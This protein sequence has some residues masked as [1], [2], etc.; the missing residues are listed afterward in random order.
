MQKTKWVHIILASLLFF[1]AVWF[2]QGRHWL[3]D[4]D[5]EKLY[6]LNVSVFGYN[7]AAAYSLIYILP[8][9][10]LLNLL[11]R[12][13]SAEITTRFDKR[14][15]L[16]HLFVYQ[17]I[18]LAVS[19]AVIQCCVNILWTT[20]FFDQSLLHQASFYQATLY[21]AIAFILF[22]LITAFCFKITE[23]ITKST[24]LSMGITVLL[25]ATSYFI[26]K[27]GISMTHWSL[28]RDVG[29]M[30]L[31]FNGGVVGINYLRLVV[32]AI[33]TSLLASMLFERKD[34]IT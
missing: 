25:F 34:F 26:E 8:F 5:Y 31:L 1:S 28:Y 30:E 9:L 33:I 15:S 32:I 10:L 17:S 20:L 27:I 24:A 3:I 19:Y 6:E 11:V 16:Y 21:N 2:F 23:T 12:H 22:Y 7:S 29:V 13:N 14:S 18:Q 4:T